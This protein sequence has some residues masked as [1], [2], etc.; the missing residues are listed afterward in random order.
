MK[1][2]YILSLLLLVGS[3]LRLYAQGI[4]TSAIN[5]LVLDEKKQPVVGALVVAK[6]EPTGTEYG[7]VTNETGVF[8]IRNMN[9]GG[10]YSVEIS[11]V[12]YKNFTAKNIYLQLG[13][14]FRI[15]AA[16]Q[17]EE[18][19]LAAVEVKGSRD[20]LFDGNRTGAKT[21]VDQ[22]IIDNV[23]PTAS[24]NLVDYLRFTPQAQ[25][26]RGNNLA[27]SF[28]GQNNRFNSIFIDGAVN[29]DVFGLAASGTNGGQTGIQPISP[30]AIEQF[31]IALSPYD[32]TIGGFTGAGVNAV[33]RS[34]TN[35]L[36]GSAYYF[37][38]NQNFAGLTPTD[39]EDFERQRLPEFTA[40]TYGVR[41]GGPIVKNKVFF[42]LNAEIQRDDTPQPFDPNYFQAGRVTEQQLNDLRQFLISQY[43]YDPGD[44]RNNTRRQRGDRLFAKVNWNLN[45]RNQ[46]MLR[47]SYV[48]A[49][50]FAPR[51][52]TA[53]RIN[54]QNN[55]VLFPSTTNSSALEWSHNNNNFANKLI[56]G[57]TTVRDDRNII[58]SPFP[59][60]QIN[61]AGGGSIV[62]GSERF[63]A[64]NR[65]DQDIL[66]LTNNFS[67]YKGRHT[68]TLGTHNEY[69]RIFNLF[70]RENYGYYVYANL[71]NFLN[72]AGPTRY[73]RSYALRPTTD[74][75]LGDD[76]ADVAAR[77]RVLQ[78]GWYVQDEFQVN[79]R[80]KL[81]G[82]FRVDIPFFLDKPEANENFN[83][84]TLP[85][86]EQEW[87]DLRGARSGNMPSGVP[88]FSPKL[89]FNY[90]VLGNQTLQL[91]GGAG[92]FTGRIPF[93]WPGG[94]YT[95][96]GVYIASIDVSNP[97]LAADNT[98]LPFNPNPQNYVAADIA[99]AGATPTQIDL[100][101]DN[102]RFPQVFRTSLAVDY[103]L[104][105]GW[106]ATLEGIYTQNINYIY[107]RDI[108]IRR[109]NANLNTPDGRPIYGNFDANA[110][111]NRYRIQRIDP[112]YVQVIWAD[113]TNQ[114]Y[115]YNL[116]ASLMR[117]L[118]NNWTAG[119]S[120]TFG[121]AR[122]IHD[123]TSSQNVSNWRFV[124]T[125]DKNALPILGFSNFDL[126]SRVMAFAG[127]QFKYS[128]YAS[129]S[130]SLFYE[131]Q[132]GRRFSYTYFSRSAGVF[133]SGDDGS[134][135]L[136]DQLFYVPRNQSEINLVDY[137]DADNNTI[138]AQQQWE[139]LNQFIENDPYLRKYRGQVIPRNGARLPFE[140][141]L[142]L[143]IIQE[144][145]LP[146]KNGKTNR[147]QVS[148]DLF[149]LTN[150]I[151][152]DWGRRRSFTNN[153]YPI[154]QM[155]GWE[156]D[157]V[158][159][160]FTFDVNTQ[161]ARRAATIEDVGIYSSRWQA[162]FGVRYIFN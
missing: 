54:F 67:I 41:V 142:D 98:P 48:Y 65:L 29:N 120:Y 47:H 71:N 68:I 72:D 27:I 28:A 24:R 16:L 36:E 162:Q 90:D 135:V 8:N 25:V 50:D 130:I 81:V 149:N 55:G 104:P 114:G 106:V 73:I 113:N 17:L 69:Y 38:R 42:F 137:V 32:V 92:I 12:G 60:V 152:K 94:A 132:S 83:Q 129:T 4:T 154:V 89:G 157:G 110:N 5:G 116:T 84:A 122:S 66:T 139:A 37:L 121:R 59:E 77:F 108:N 107:Y 127:Y 15:E 80:L 118:N 96:N 75:A 153:I 147:L 140:H 74:A 101:T 112:A 141:V 21:I 99:G 49:E 138:T 18:Y 10:P 34:G 158:T 11:F 31:N 93:V 3:A 155:R 133:V 103:K 19:Q 160:R 44:F 146:M 143:K 102:F 97:R 109:P 6:H 105:L 117:P 2:A 45:K 145:M 144:F 51:R 35:N 39:R 156:P 9:V 111:P 58:G 115:T 134:G 87:G 62:F 52:S 53:Q 151:D 100:F 79:N 33:T 63:S 82:G 23:A 26:L 13:Q 1:N 91:R 161:S 126:G 61:D 7:A 20:D 56:L 86:L 131:G 64:G 150:F 14:T 128:K 78:T 57:F 22:H 148:F 76:A 46:L 30:D 125:T 95:N 124:E 159:P 40:Q 70:L 136:N 88:M 123:A 119:L 43:N 85:L